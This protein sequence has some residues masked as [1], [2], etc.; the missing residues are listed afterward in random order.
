MRRALTMLLIVAVIVVVVAAVNHSVIFNLKYVAGTAHGVSLLW[1]GVGVALVVLVF[2]TV[3]AWMAQRGAA[4]VRRKVERE[5]EGTY[6]RLREAEAH[7][8]TAVPEAPPADSA[9]EP[10][11]EPEPSEPDAAQEAPSRDA[12]PQDAPAAGA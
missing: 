9:T 1:L 2:G 12:P 3:A 6:V 8:P 5:L 10:T 11:A 4:T 7:V